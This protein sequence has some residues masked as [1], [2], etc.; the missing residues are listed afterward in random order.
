MRGAGGGAGGCA[1]GGREGGGALNK[2]F[3]I[4][5]EVVGGEL[6]RRSI[7]RRAATYCARGTL[8]TLYCARGTLGTLYY[9]TFF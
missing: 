7:V 1:G 3:K 4:E 2:L 5:H 9:T 8:G 6:W